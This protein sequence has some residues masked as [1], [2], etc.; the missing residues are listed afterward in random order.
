MQ[1]KLILLLLV[2]LLAA[3][4]TLQ[5]QIKE[6]PYNGI[7]SNVT[8]FAKDGD[9]FWL[10]LN[11]EKQN[12][13][14]AANV[15]IGNLASYNYKI[16]V[17]FENAKIPSLDAN[18]YARDTDNNALNVVYEI[19][20]NKKG[21]SMVMRLVSDEIIGKANPSTMPETP[22]FI[23]PAPASQTAPTAGQVSMNIKVPDIN[24]QSGNMD[25]SGNSLS[26]TMPAVNNAAANY[27]PP[28]RP[29]APKTATPGCQQPMADA[30]FQTQLATVKK[31]SF[32]DTKLKTAKTLLSKNCVSTN[33]VTQ[34]LKTFSF[35]GDKLEMAKFA[36]PYT[37]DKENYLNLSEVFSFSSS[38]SELTKFLDA[39]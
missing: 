33:Q 10:I 13:T 39:Q 8:V 1:R 4:A 3:T 32:S 11:G 29:M 37:V 20:K 27:N 22:D 16:K 19:K 36:Y 2:C 5:A 6:N 7:P 18:M 12:T 28:P 23:K 25:V 14:P 31:Q 9:K 38:T 21:N 35:E 17:I 15:K 34:L 24:G 30:T 26:V